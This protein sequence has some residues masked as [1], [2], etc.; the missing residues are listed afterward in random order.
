VGEE[1]RLQVS[2][3]EVLR[4]LHE[5]KGNAVSEERRTLYNKEVIDSTHE[6]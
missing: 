1:N 6:T 2:G 4:E 3:K 5:V